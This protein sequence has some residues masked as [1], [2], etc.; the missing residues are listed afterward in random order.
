MIVRCH[1]DTTV[2]DAIVSNVFGPLD[3]KG[4][5]KVW[6]ALAEELTGEHPSLMIDL[7]EVDLITSAGIGTL[8]RIHHRVHKLGGTL[9][10]YGANTRAREVI[11]AVMLADILNLCESIE[12]ARTSLAG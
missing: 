11:E 10:L 4:A 7:S 3:E 12:D 8:V 9:A 6:D 5:V 1:I 2:E